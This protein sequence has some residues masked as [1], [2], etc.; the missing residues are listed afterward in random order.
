[1]SSSSLSLAT[2]ERAALADLLDELGPAAPTC[3]EGW[4]TAHLAAHLAVRDRRLDASPGYGAENL[5]FGRSFAR[6]SHRV[7]DRLRARKPY[8]EIVGRVRS[9]P[10]PWSPF[11][12]PKLAGVL[13][14]SEY[15]IHHEDVRRAQP[16]WAPRELSREDQDELWASVLFFG[17]L[18]SG[19]RPGSLLLRRT[20]APRVQKR[21]GHGEPETTVEGEALELLLWASGREDVARVTVS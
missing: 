12:W 13:N 16:G 21:F 15:T 9:G 2:R 5:P 11:A 14:T 3:C 7:E 18:A 6:W 1:M 19:R 8:P 20:D 4:Q 10:P 17:R